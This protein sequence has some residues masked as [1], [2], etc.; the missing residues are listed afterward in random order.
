VA[1]RADETLVLTRSDV[2]GLL[3]MRDCIEALEE[4]FRAQAA[5][6][7]LPSAVLGVH[8]PE[9]GLHVKAAGLDRGRLYVAAKLNANIPANPER[10]GRPTIQGVIALFD[11][12]DGRPLALMDSIE[13]TALRTGA[14]TAVAA[15]HMARP[16]AA[17]LAICGCGAQAAY[18]ARALAA[19]RPLRRVLAH[20]RDPARAERLRDALSADPALPVTVVHDLRSALR[21]AE[22]IV[23]CTPSKR[24]L[25]GP[26]HVRPG[27]FVAGVGADNPEKQELDP[28]LLARSRVVVD[29]L[30]QAATIGD[31]HHALLSQALR[32]EDVA[33]ELW[34]VAAGRKPGRLS[35]GEVTVF[36]STGVA[37]EDAAAAALVYER[38]L[39]AGRGRP[40]ALAD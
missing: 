22:L 24:P 18:Q 19:V 27:S 33:G 26:E 38:A 28:L 30:E 9:G 10:R 15:K 32:K 25:L 39:G 23:T 17:V 16:G 6:R 4:A 21:E 7:T 13:V 12:E 35:D 5:G 1:S 20:D 8:L 29:S 36:D 2:A 40:L 34:E 3:P 11:G 14:A 31:L 37:L